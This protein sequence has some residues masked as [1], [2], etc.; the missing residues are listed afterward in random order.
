[1][2]HP[3]QRIH[4]RV[5][6]TMTPAATTTVPARRARSAS[7]SRQ[8]QYCI[9]VKSILLHAITDG[10]AN[11]MTMDDEGLVFPF[12]GTNERS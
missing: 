1:M 8:T 3:M 9:I 5:C 6:N 10:G 2:S 12:D 4:V 11:T 7:G